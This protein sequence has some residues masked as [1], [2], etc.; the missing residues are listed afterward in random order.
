MATGVMPR[1][2]SEHASC[3]RISTAAFLLTVVLH[4]WEPDAVGG[5]SSVTP[6]NKLAGSLV[7]ALDLLS[8]WF[9][10][11]HRGGGEKGTGR[12]SS[13]GRRTGLV[14]PCCP[15]IWEFVPYVQMEADIGDPEL[16][17]RWFRRNY[18]ARAGWPVPSTTRRIFGPNGGQVSFLPALM[19]EWEA[20][21]PQPGFCGAICGGHAGPSG[22]SPAPAVILS[23]EEQQ[24]PDCV[25]SLL[26]RVLFVRFGDRVVIFCFSRV[27]FVRCCMPPL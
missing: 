27:L 2:R 8:S 19:P 13:S 20:V 12:A 24:G 16:T 1:W 5:D 25:S 11:S 15:R 14:R 26:F 4:W 9:F 3:V 22:P 21:L 23:C 7:L 6:L 17:R 10:S 18:G